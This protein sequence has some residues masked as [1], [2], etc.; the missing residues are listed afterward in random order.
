M[1]RDIVLSKDG[2]E[3]FM[4]LMDAPPCR[5][6]VTSGYYPGTNKRISDET[7]R[8]SSPLALGKLKTLAIQQGMHI[9][10]LDSIEAVPLDE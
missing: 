7:I 3:A 8:L 2:F 9:E 4:R 10:E 6:Y 1:I 5:T